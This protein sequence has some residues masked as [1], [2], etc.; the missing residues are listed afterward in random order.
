MKTRMKPISLPR[1]AQGMSLI[2][3]MVA[4]MVLAVGLLGV[5]AMQ[6]LGKV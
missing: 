6:A 4:V 2:E 3:V 5:A 1:H